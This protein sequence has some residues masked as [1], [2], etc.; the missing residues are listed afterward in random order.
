MQNRHW[1]ESLSMV[2]KAELE[3]EL[4][5]LRTRNAQLEAKS[6]DSPVGNGESDN[7][8]HTPTEEVKRLLAEHGIDLAKTEEFGEKVAEELERLQKSYPMTSM[9][10]VFALGYVIGRTQK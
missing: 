2:T 4:E 3:I 1:K 10:A 7:A 5:K 6:K 9:I 8:A